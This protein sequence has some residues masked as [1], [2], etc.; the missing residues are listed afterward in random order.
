MRTR[1]HATKA[2]NARN[3][4]Q[5]RKARQ[6]RQTKRSQRGGSGQGKGG[7]AC[8]T[9]WGTDNCLPGLACSK[10]K[11]CEPNAFLNN[12]ISEFLQDHDWDEYNIPKALRAY[13]H[14]MNV[15]INSNGDTLLLKSVMAESHPDVVREVLKHVRDVNA[16]NKNGVTALIKAAQNNLPHLVEVLLESRRADVNAVNNNHSNALHL[17]ALDKQNWSPKVKFDDYRKHHLRRKEL[18]RMLLEAGIH[19]D[20]QTADGATFLHSVLNQPLNKEMSAE[21]N[22]ARIQEQTELVQMVLDKNA[23]ANLQDRDGNIPLHFAGHNPAVVKLLLE[24]GSNVGTA[25]IAGETPLAKFT[26]E[27]DTNPESIA[28]IKQ[29]FTSTPAF[30]KAVQDNRLDLVK[31]LIKSKVDINKRNLRN[32]GGGK[33][34]LHMIEAPMPVW[35]P[36]IEFKTY[37]EN[38]LRR[39]EMLHVLLEAGIHVDAQ[40][41]KGFTVLHYL[42]HLNPSVVKGMP[43]EE[44]RAREHEQTEF[45]QMLLLKNANV[46]LQDQNGNTP[47]HYAYSNPAVVKLLLAAGSNT[48]IVNKKGETPL[49]MFNRRSGANPECIALL[50]EAEE[51]L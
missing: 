37:R 35:S 18:V 25:N 49:Q 29:T 6:S 43:I 46:N 22:Q 24:A 23:D 48:A 7:E 12:F 50:S 4:G 26:R 21:E 19:V 30:L 20:A 17:I 14:L 13:T 40:T 1:K 15:P 36:S 9:S 33:S 10:E 27:A 51:N 41:Q 2:R 11:R 8:A 42:A 28:L 5:S 39:K 45:V 38:H 34:A 3:A 47:L 44:I 16:K 32:D 31:L